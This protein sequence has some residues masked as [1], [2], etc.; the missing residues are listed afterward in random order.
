MKNF[1]KNP[2]GKIFLAG[3]SVM[4]LG[5]INLLFVKNLPFVSSYS[6][7]QLLWI[8]ISLII[9]FIISRF[10]LQTI[11]SLSIPFYLFT[12]I[13]LVYVLFFGD[14][15]SGAELAAEIIKKFTK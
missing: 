6:F 11:K 14:R 8:F 12:L 4:F 15:I 10:R 5:F 1:I 7:K 3:F 2:E 9:F 13:L